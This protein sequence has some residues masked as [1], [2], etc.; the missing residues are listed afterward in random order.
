[1]CVFVRLKPYICLVL[2]VWKLPLAS[3]KKWVHNKVERLSYKNITIYI[4]YPYKFLIFT[5]TH[6]YIII[7]VFKE[8]QVNYYITL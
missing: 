7:F 2:D 8:M 3:V 1:M 4:I 5:Y 6:T